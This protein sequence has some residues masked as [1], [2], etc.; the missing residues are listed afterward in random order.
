MRDEL[1]IYAGPEN[2][3]GE[4]S[5]TV[6]DP[7]RNRFFRIDWLT[8]QILNR[9]SFGESGLIAQ[10]VSSVAPLQID[11]TDVQSVARFLLDNELIK[12]DFVGATSLLVQR[13]QQRQKSWG[14]WLLHHYLFIRIP[15][16]R[17]DALLTRYVD[18]FAP[19]TSPVFLRLTV[20]V[21]LF[22]LWQLGR[23]WEAF[24]SSFVDAM[25][26]TGAISY[27]ATLIF[28][29]VL[30]E[31]GHG[32][33]AKHY[34][35]RVPTMG[36]AFLVLWPVA[37]TDVTDTWKLADK[38]Q[39]LRVACAGVATELMIAVWA[40]AA[41]AILPDG[42]LRTAAFLLA[43]TTWLSAIV[44]N[45]NPLM[46]FDGYYILSDWLDIPNLHDRAFAFA[47]WY[48]RRV[49]LGLQE[50]PPEVLPLATR[51]TLIV[52]AFV[53]W[54]YRLALYIG[55][56]VLVYHFFVKAVGIG[57]FIVEMWWFIFRPV[58]SELRL[59][60]GIRG[61]WAKNQRAR[62]SMLG[63][64]IGL[65]VLLLPLPLPVTA[66]AVLSPEQSYRIRAPEPGRIVALPGRPGAE[67]GTGDLVAVLES[68][69]ADSDAEVAQ[70]QVEGL[71]SQ[72]SA[73]AVDPSQRARLL[74]LQADLQAAEA[75]LS[76]RAQ[77]A[78]RFELRS[79]R[80]GR[81]VDGDPDLRLGEWIAKGTQ[82]AIIAAPGAW[83]AYA[84]V[85]AEQAR[86]L[87]VGDAARLVLPGGATVRLRV[88]DIE[89][90][91]ARVL[92][93]GLLTTAAGGNV[94]VRIEDSA[95]VPEGSVF[96]VR[97]TTDDLPASLQGRSWRG[98]L[99]VYGDW[100]SIGWRYLQA[101]AAL[102]VREA[103]F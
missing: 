25:T 28:V 11:D 54:L 56:A 59:W 65:G 24:S 90:D 12:A 1:V 6:H 82:I 71:R 51:R 34:G 76:S 101:A 43:T 26:V 80:Q 68:P 75:Q 73:A 15:L 78:G 58:A 88:D 32:F 49:V 94:V 91:A 48:L 84:Y 13:R 103:S 96:R 21:L 23:Q 4:P 77:R 5:W 83:L 10:S 79:P 29:K 33:V 61:S 14:E 95:M 47:R 57:L 69:S 86:R 9:W 44:V 55:I 92:P 30:H 99:M 52:L 20:L 42:S 2:V 39:R 98:Q 62:L 70:A 19:L 36:V 100:S 97:L 22:G 17:P 64:A 18:K 53:T 16:V 81:V 31:L 3:A 35:C 27:G 63:L 67:L 66:S 89:Q 60:W 45:F 38:R 72:L 85:D 37:Y 46:R 8:Y 87:S 41:W 74:G 50:E 40:T 102:V 7:A 93:N